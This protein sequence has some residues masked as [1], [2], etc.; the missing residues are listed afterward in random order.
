MIWI[1]S[2]NNKLIL[3]ASKNKK[4]FPIWPILTL[5]ECAKKLNEKNVWIGFDAQKKLI[6][7]EAQ[8]NK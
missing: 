4:L 3:M 8:T 1:L 2:E 7:L 6:C 5:T